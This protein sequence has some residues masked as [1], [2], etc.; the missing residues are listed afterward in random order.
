MFADPFGGEI[1]YASWARDNHENIRS[2]LQI[3]NPLSAPGLAEDS[4]LLI[5][6]WERDEYRWNWVLEGFANLAALCATTI[7]LFGP[8]LQHYPSLL[9]AMNAV[10]QAVASEQKAWNKWR[11]R[12]EQRS[13]WLSHQSLDVLSKYERPSGY[14]PTE[15]IR[16]L[17]NLAVLTWRLI[18]AS[19]HVLRDWDSPPPEEDAVIG[20]TRFGWSEPRWRDQI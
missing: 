19:T 13:N 16:N 2:M 5:N 3:D 11:Q 8:S 18:A 1:G 14:L 4:S 7:H 17:H 15:A 20:S 12:N 9:N 6:D 10:Q